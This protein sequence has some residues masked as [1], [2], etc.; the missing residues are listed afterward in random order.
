VRTEPHRVCFTLQHGAVRVHRTRSD[1]LVLGRVDAQQFI[2]GH[3][4]LRGA[5]SV[6]LADDVPPPFSKLDYVLVFGIL[7]ALVAL[8]LLGVFPAATR[9]QRAAAQLLVLPRVAV[10]HYR[11]NMASERSLLGLDNMAL[12]SALVLLTRLAVVGTLCMALVG[13]RIDRGISSDL[14]LN[15]T[16]AL[17]ALAMVLALRG[18]SWPLPRA[19][20]AALG[21][22]HYSNALLAVCWLMA[23][24]HARQF[25][26]QLLMAG[27]AS[28]LCWRTG[29]MFMHVLLEP[30]L[31]HRGLA[32]LRARAQWLWIV[33]AALCCAIAAWLFC[34]FTVPLLLDEW[35]DTTLFKAPLI[36][37]AAL[38]VCVFRP[39]HT[40]YSRYF[41]R[42]ESALRFALEI[43][44]THIDDAAAA[45]KAHH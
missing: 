28:V 25:V 8:W 12:L 32:L 33:D 40:F 5:Y 10:A 23:A 43:G 27:A 20:Y 1:E 7:L 11:A 14:P 24:L 29:E 30:L 41:E 42:A 16:R 35:W 45:N 18:A 39:L 31:A 3:D 38:L 13:F 2:L 6:M 21:V 17:C 15:Y 37:A 4:V 34:G 9:P 22:Y 26:A 19:S 36:V 44:Q